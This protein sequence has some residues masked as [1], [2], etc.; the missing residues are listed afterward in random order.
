[1]LDP[2]SPAD[3]RALLY[4]HPQFNWRL[5][6]F[7][8]TAN[9]RT[10]TALVDPSRFGG[11]NLGEFQYSDGWIRIPSLSVAEGRIKI[12]GALS[13]SGLQHAEADNW[14]AGGA[15]PYEWTPPGLHPDQ[16]DECYRQVLRETYVYNDLP[17]TP[18]INGNFEDPASTEWLGQDADVEY[19]PDT[20]AGKV[21]SWSLSV[22]N[23]NPGIAGF[24]W[25]REGLS[26]QPGQ[27]Y[28]FD[29]LVRQST[30]PLEAVA[31][32]IFDSTN[33]LFGTELGTVGGAI[34]YGTTPVLLRQEITIP[35]GCYLVRCKMQNSDNPDSVTYWDALPGRLLSAR[36]FDLQDWSAARF[37]IT[38]VSEVRY[39]G[40]LQAGTQ[41]Y[42]ASTRNAH[43]WERRRDF[44]TENFGLNSTPS[45]LVVTRP[46]G[47]PSDVE[48][49]YSSQRSYA[50]ADDALLDENSST[51][52]PQD[53][54]VPAFLVK[55]CD[56][57]GSDAPP[58]V[59]AY[60]QGLIEAQRDARKQK[61]PPKRGQFISTGVG[62]GR[63]GGG[64][65]PW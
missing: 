31:W 12:A 25:S 24:A 63:R 60:N 37:N 53:Q 6:G 9:S 65:R 3:I 58:G 59:R 16:V 19:L 55:V 35:E 11:T 39:G 47:I 34:A 61:P 28:Q 7:A 1:M 49:W 4:N 10:T 41:A 50:D 32:R 43:A 13:G 27:R 64:Y 46:S 21:G 57:L 51:R 45:A 44:D 14:A 15:T 23:N 20:A 26:V 40:A 36:R 17:E 18:W 5:V 54:L 29:A 2:L 22:A 56:L 38:G 48:L 8:S 62:A 52:C 30:K 33:V 42:D